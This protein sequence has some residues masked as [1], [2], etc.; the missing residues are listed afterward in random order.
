MNQEFL[1]DLARNPNAMPKHDRLGSGYGQ[2]RSKS[3]SRSKGKRNGS[4][5][6]RGRAAAQDATPNVAAGVML[7][8]SKHHE[9]EEVFH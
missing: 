8:E 4:A 5:H 1:G 9:T 3:R 6:S 2:Q 7:E